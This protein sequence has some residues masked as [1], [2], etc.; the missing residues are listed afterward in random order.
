MR[1][2]YDV[3]TGANCRRRWIVKGYSVDECSL[4]DGS[5]SSVQIHIICTVFDG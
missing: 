1:R 4:F 5:Q 2:R 3:P